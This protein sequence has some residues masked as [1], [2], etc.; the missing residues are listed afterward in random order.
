MHPPQLREPRLEAEPHLPVR[1]PRLVLRD[2]TRWLWAVPLLL[3]VPLVRPV[4]PRLVRHTR[5]RVPLGCC[6]K[7]RANPDPHL[8][9]LRRPGLDRLLL[10]LPLLDVDS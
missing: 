5:G 7:R 6:R 2:R 9:V 1:L 8:G 3:Q 10:L 4:A